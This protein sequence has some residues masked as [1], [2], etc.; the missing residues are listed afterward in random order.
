MSVLQL[1]GSA[2]MSESMQVHVTFVYICSWPFGRRI[3]SNTHAADVH[4]P[5]KIAW[6]TWR[7]PNSSSW[8]WLW[9]R[10]TWP[11]HASMLS[12]Y[13]HWVQLLNSAELSLQSFSQQNQFGC[14]YQEWT[15]T[16]LSS[17][18]PNQWSGKTWQLDYTEHQAG[19]IRFA[20]LV[21][22]AVFASKLMVATWNEKIHGFDFPIKSRVE[23]VS[24]S[25]RIGRTRE[26]HPPD[27]TSQHL[28]CRWTA[29]DSTQTGVSQPPPCVGWEGKVLQLQSF[30]PKKKKDPE[31]V[32]HISSHIQILYIYIY[33]YIYRH[34]I[35][36]I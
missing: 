2:S 21:R 3:I 22:C 36:Y 6:R 15:S 4:R 35:M 24:P 7:S 28:Q 14:W 12:R 20:E 31:I 30:R 1:L 23:R 8:C 19:L 26:H 5:C 29:P 11:G 34:S 33:N 10:S 17:F 27:N 9:K 13:S 16:A 25:H 32:A 18:P